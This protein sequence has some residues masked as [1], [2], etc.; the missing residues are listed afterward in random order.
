MSEIDLSVFCESETSK[1]TRYDLRKPWYQ[2]GYI[3]ATDARI[4]V[5]VPLDGLAPLSEKGRKVPVS[6]SD[7][8]WPRT[9]KGWRPWPRKRWVKPSFGTSHICPV[10]DGKG[11]Q[12]DHCNGVGEGSDFASIQKIGGRIIA[13][14]Y[15]RRIRALPDVAYLLVGKTCEKPIAFRFDGGEGL[16]YVLTQE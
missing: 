4:C 14:H 9:E 12:C 13:A 11:Q 6:A 3:Y 10:C 7:L 2:D 15:D 5:R 1:S 8:D 16:I